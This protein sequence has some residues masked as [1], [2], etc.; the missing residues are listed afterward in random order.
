M[1][2]FRLLFDLYLTFAEGLVP[3]SFALYLE[4]TRYEKRRVKV[5]HCLFRKFRL[6]IVPKIH[7]GVMNSIVK[8]KHQVS[9]QGI[10]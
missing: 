10:T 1:R 7:I 2:D 6:S 9:K 5:V 8:R 3:A 4:K